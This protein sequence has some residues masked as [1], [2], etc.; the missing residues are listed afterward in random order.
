MFALILKC[1]VD[2]LQTNMPFKRGR[3][4]FK[5]KKMKTFECYLCHSTIKNS[6]SNLK[7]HFK[8]HG[9]KIKCYVCLECGKDYQNRSNLRKHWAKS[10]DINNQI[11]CLIDWKPAKGEQLI[12]IYL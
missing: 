1:Q 12:F 2:C 4:K 10:H 6:F 7:R 11:Q 5:K 9:P 8:L 3:I